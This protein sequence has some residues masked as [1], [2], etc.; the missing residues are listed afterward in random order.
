MEICKEISILLCKVNSILKVCME[1][2]CKDCN[3]IICSR[4]MKLDGILD[5]MDNISR[6][7]HGI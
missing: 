2:M 5:I 1:H 4:C 6:E 7:K 3:D